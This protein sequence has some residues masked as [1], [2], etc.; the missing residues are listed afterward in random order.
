[1][2]KTSKNGNYNID[3]KVDVAYNKHEAEEILLIGG[4]YY[5]QCKCNDCSKYCS[6]S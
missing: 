4:D 2:N 6:D 3:C 5:A 1:M